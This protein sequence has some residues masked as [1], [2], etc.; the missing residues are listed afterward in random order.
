[1]RGGIVTGTPARVEYGGCFIM[2]FEKMMDLVERKLKNPE[3]GD[4]IEVCPDEVRIVDDASG[5][6]VC[7]SRGLW[8]A[9]K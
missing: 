4:T 9:L 3:W 5:D 8:D 7:M 2:D 1:M 6:C